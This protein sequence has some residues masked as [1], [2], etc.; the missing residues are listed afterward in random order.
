MN[1]EKSRNRPI[2][3]ETKLMV[4]RGKGGLGKMGEGEGKM[5]SSGYGISKSWG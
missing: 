1:K 5:Q 2:N 4:T 3:P